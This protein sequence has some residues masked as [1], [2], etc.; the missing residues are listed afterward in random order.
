MK[1]EPTR[2]KWQDSIAFLWFFLLCATFLLTSYILW[3]KERLLKYTYGQGNWKLSFLYSF[4]LFSQL[5]KQLIYKILYTKD[6]ERMQDHLSQHSQSRLFQCYSCSTK[7]CSLISLNM[8]F[9]NNHKG[10]LISEGFHF[11]HILKKMC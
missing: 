6:H 8:H 9:N 2:T 10:G 11:G 7:R 4:I 1:F 3:E 5:K